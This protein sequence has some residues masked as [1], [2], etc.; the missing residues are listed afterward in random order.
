MKPG[1]PFAKQFVKKVPS[2]A[3]VC[4]F[5]LKRLPSRKMEGR[6]RLG[7]GGSYTSRSAWLA[8]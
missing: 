6:G 5:A 4:R 8:T 7:A 1:Q 3:A 2:P